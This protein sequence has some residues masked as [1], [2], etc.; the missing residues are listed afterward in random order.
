MKKGKLPRAV[1]PLNRTRY[2]ELCDRVGEAKLNDD[3]CED[4][5]VAVCKAVQAT[6]SPHETE[7]SKRWNQSTR[8][9]LV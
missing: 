2:E 1:I 3:A 7:R 8:A 6:S 9:F 4:F 5:F